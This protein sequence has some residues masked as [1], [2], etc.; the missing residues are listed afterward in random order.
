M[1]HKRKLMKDKILEINKILNNL[2]K[3]VFI[4]ETK[5]GFLLRDHM[6]RMTFSLDLDEYNKIINQNKKHPLGKIFKKGQLNILDCTGGFARDAAIISSLGNNV[7]MIEENQIVMCI[8]NEAIARIQNN[9]IKSIFKRI[10]T[11]LGNCLD[12]VK[13]TDKVY[14]Y[15]YFD[16]MFNT[17][18]TALPSKRDQF[19][20]KIVKN[21]IDINRDIVEEVLQRVNCKVIIKENIKSNNYQ[22]LNIINTYK[23]KVVK[24]H[25]L[26]GKNE[27][28]KLH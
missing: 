8:L 22:H 6:R 25:L 4:E 15:I 18:K 14:D 1:D 2:S 10:S 26:Q 16:F 17:S 24:Y 12:Y 3:N 7:T 28:Y 19:L 9:E 23:E 20:R 13:T 21:N 5:N 27:H 11:K